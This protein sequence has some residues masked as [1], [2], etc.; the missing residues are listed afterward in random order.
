M[1]AAIASASTA[2]GTIDPSGAVGPIGGIVQKM[3]A[4]KAAG[5]TVFLAPSDNCSET[6]GKTPSGLKVF[7]VKQLKQAVDIL[8]A[9]QSGSSLSGFATCSK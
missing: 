4:A 5:A 1:A 6:V 7:K 2:T 3:Y 8:T 9:M